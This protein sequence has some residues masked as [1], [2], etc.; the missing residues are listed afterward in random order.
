[1]QVVY[2]VFDLT[3]FPGRLSLRITLEYKIQKD[4]RI[5]DAEHTVSGVKYHNLSTSPSNDLNL[6]LT[7]IHIFLY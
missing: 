1:M 6:Y 5:V 3:S 4:V 7:D 2:I